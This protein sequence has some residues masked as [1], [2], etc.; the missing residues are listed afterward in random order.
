MITKYTIY[1]ERCSGT[2]Y[3]EQLL[4]INFDATLTWK[5]GWKHFFGFRN[6]NDSDDTLFICIV[7]NPYTWI[8]SLYKERHHL[9]ANFKDKNIFLHSTIYSKDD[10]G[11]EI[12]EDKHIFKNR[13]YK[14]IFELRYT[15]LE[16]MIEHLPKLVKN[17]V[18]IK[19]EDLLDNFNETMK[20]FVK[21]GLQVKN[22]IEFPLNTK[23]YKKTKN[24]FDPNKKN[25]T[26]PYSTITPLLNLHYEKL[27]GYEII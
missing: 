24:I 3:L 16:Y 6:L 11:K 17:Y 21:C 23:Y 19:Y 9:P 22:N 15:K 7:R 10:N 27:L 14:N 1:G 12:I 25:I 20:I 26:I 4:N 2:N 8:N 5:Y 13:H 18:F